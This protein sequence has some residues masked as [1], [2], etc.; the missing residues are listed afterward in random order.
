MRV[1]HVITGLA[2]G[3]AETQLRLLL[4]HTRHQ[5]EVVS[6]TNPGSV[7]EAIRSDGTPVVNLS[8]RSN[9][10][11]QAVPRLVGLIRSGQYD[12]VHTHL[13]RAC[14]YGRLAARLAR[15]PLV[16]ATEHSLLEGQIE[17]RRATAGVRA[18][19]RVSERLGDVTIAVSSVVRQRLIQWG[20]AEHRIVYIPN[21]IDPAGL[22]FRAEDRALVREDL[23]VPANATVVGAVGRLDRGKNLDVIISALAPLLRQDLI[24]VLVGDGPERRSLAEL[25]TSLGAAD[26]V[27][28]AGERGNIGPILSAMDVFVSASLKETFGLATLE[29]LANGL[30]VIYGVCPALDELEIPVPG[31][32]RAKGVDGMRAAVAE[33]AAR[34]AGARVAPTAIDRYAVSH[35]AAAIDDLYDALWD[36]RRSRKV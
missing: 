22:R 14:L 15:V 32:L 35:T 25:A 12:A 5:A 34:P 17:R 31:A 20:V 26:R 28:F 2:A 8:M 11:P 3:G 36:Q 24:L 6:L 4:R 10:E 30:P 33:A 7:A 23:R 18:L 9:L 21:G 13:Y 27:I 16:V 19:Y 29:A 1:L